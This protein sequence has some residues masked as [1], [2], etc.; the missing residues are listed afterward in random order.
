MILAGEGQKA[1]RMVY[2]GYIREAW[3]EFNGAPEVVFNI[4]SEAGGIERMKPVPALSY[5]GAADAVVIME[6]LAKTMGL[7][8]ENNGVD[9]IM[10]D[11]PYFPGT[12]TVQAEA[13]A[14]AANIG[15]VLDDD[16]LVIFP[17]FGQ[18]SKGDIP[19]ISPKTGLVGYPSYS[20]GAH[21]A[22]RTLYNPAITFNGTIKVEGSQVSN[23]N[24][25]WR[26]QA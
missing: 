1:P 10:L 22:L 2:E 3:P 14:R 4:E 5:P 11:N 17:I 6:G 25:E 21:I 9:P 23:A 7:K 24:G 16:K 26:V 18:R 15:W 8:F 13:C 19:V 20:A 12:A